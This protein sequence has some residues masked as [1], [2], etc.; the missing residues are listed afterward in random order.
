MI[1]NTPSFDDENSLSTTKR[2]EIAH[3]LKLALPGPHAFVFVL[4]FTPDSL[5]S[6]ENDKQLTES[7]INIFG[8]E[9]FQYIVFVFTNLEKL[10]EDGIEI[11]Q[12]M[13]KNRSQAFT[14]LMKICKNRFIV[15]NNQAPPN[16][17]DASFAE[18]IHTI[19]RMLKENEG[20]GYTYRSYLQQQTSKFTMKV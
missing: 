13:K 20:K 19:D 2:I 14:D 7:L 18:L 8:P 9:V 12:Y 3:S 1:V 15:I 6:E 10:Q 16:A 17:K 11:D 5:P 4:E